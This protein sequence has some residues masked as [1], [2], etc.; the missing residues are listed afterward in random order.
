MHLSFVLNSLIR[1]CPKNIDCLLTLCIPQADSKRCRQKSPTAAAFARRRW[2]GVPAAA[3][4][5]GGA[6][7][8]RSCAAEVQGDGGGQRRR[9]SFVDGEFRRHGFGGG[10][11]AGER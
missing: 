4:G 8:G 3:G 5:G 11:C 2:E 10:G 7:R 6:N 9:Q 1:I